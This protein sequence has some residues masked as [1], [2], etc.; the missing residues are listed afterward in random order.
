MKKAR[1]RKYAAL[2]PGIA[3]IGGMAAYP[4]IVPA[5]EAGLYLGGGLGYFRINE[6]DFLD[7]DDDFKD[8]RWSW[9]VHAGAQ[10]NPIF[11]VEAGYVDY[12]KLN[13]GPL[14]LEADG[15]FAA[16]LVHLPLTPMFAPFGKIGYLWWDADLRGQGALSPVTASE[17]GSDMFYGVGLRA[18]LSPNV[19]LRFE[20]D[21]MSL[22]D[23]DIDMGS[24]SLQYLF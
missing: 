18:T 21:R 6:D 1:A 10:F 23:A 8:N 9:K 15:K 2:I 13:D 5:N 16:A 12:G 7:E 11:S 20:Y 4:T 3:L 19:Q 24:V 22:D 14:E 17:D